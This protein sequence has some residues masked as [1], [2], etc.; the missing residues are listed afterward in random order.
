MTWTTQKTG[1]DTE[2]LVWS[3]VETG[4]APSPL[5]GTATLKNVNLNTETGEAMCSFARFQQ[6]QTNLNGTGTLAYVSTN[7]LSYSLFDF[8][9]VAGIWI[10]V[11]SSSNTGELPNQDYYVQQSASGNI[12]ISNYYG[13]AVI[14]G[15]TAGLTANFVIK[16]NISQPIA[17]ATEAYFNG[18]QQ[19]RYYMLDSA[20]YVWVY[21]TATANSAIGLSW[22]LPDTAMPYIYASGLAVLNGWLMVV[23]SYGIYAKSV[24]NLGGNTS[25]ATTWAALIDSSGT[26][27]LIMRPL[28][29]IPHPAFVGHQGRMYY[30]DGCYLGVIFPNSSLNPNVTIPNVQSFCSYAATITEGSIGEIISG[31]APTAGTADGTRIPAMFFTAQGGTIPNALTALTI[32]YIEYATGGSFTVFAAASGGSALN[33]ASGANGTQYFNTFWPLAMASD[34][35]ITFQSSPQELNLPT[36]E[37]AQCMGE[38]GNTLMVGCYGNIVYPWNQSDPTPS[39]LIA[40]PEANCVTM[41]NAHNFMYLFAG[42]KGNVYISDGSEASHVISIPDYCAGLDGTPSSYIEPVYTFGDSM[43]LRGRVYFSLQDQT[44]SKTGNCG[45]IWSFVPTQQLTIGLDIGVSLC[46]ENQNSYGTYNG[47]ASVLIP[48]MNQAAIAPQFW[49]GWTAFIGGGSGGYGIDFT[50]TTLANA[51]IETDILASGT[52]LQKKS[53]AQQEYKL[54]TPLLSGESVQLNYRLNSTDAWTSC[55]SVIAEPNSLSGYFTA[56]FQNTQWLQI[57][58]ILTSSGTTTFSGNRLTNIFLR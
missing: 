49:S 34:Q 3:G 1:K 31:S 27:M 54:S 6:S 36:F 21:D 12:E 53:W 15:F 42:N 51:T 2:D 24:I 11:S 18:S 10:T 9:L 28:E 39:S 38:V 26:Q 48:S 19:Y 55:G 4:I 37:V 43:Y 8:N 45:G 40:L 22:F 5:K 46:L 14:T 47:L 29:Q 57:Q 16:V 44:A 20:G 50:G 32:Y 17:R 41:V 52:M 56:A 58:A 7:Q 33:L 23:T 13:S 35:P 25:A 30:G